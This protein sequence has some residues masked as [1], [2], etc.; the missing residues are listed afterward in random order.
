MLFAIIY[1]RKY[2][3]LLYK[4]VFIFLLCNARNQNSFLNY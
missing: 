4:A 1:A 2:T 3:I